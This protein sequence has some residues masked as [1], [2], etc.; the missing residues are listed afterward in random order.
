MA[1]IV[2][3]DDGIEFDG[4]T[5]LERPLGGAESSVV[6]LAQALAA[7]GHDVIACTN[8]REEVVHLGVRWT[9][10]HTD[11]DYGGLPAAADLYIA[12][13][14]DRLIDL[15]PAARRT[16][17]WIHNPAGYILKWRYLAKLWRV[18]PVIVFIGS[19]H[20]AGCPKWVPDGGRMTIPY[21]IS[22]TFLGRQPL[23]AP[24]PPRAVFTSNPLRGLDWILDLWSRHIHPYVPAAELRVYSGAATYGGVGAAKAGA[25]EAVLAKARALAGQGVLVCQ[26]LAKEALAEALRAARVMLYRGDENETFCL[27]VGEAQALGLPAVVGPAGSMAERV[28]DGVTGFVALD[29]RQFSGRAR[30][31]LTDDGLWRRCHEAALKSRGRWTWIDAAGAF[32]KLIP[33]GGV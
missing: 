16:V 17:F 19:Y 26:P 15:M 12:N 3:A 14:G 8:C 29:D 2:I 33:N 1:R 10:V 22:A 24:P 21:G 27:A 11:S 28:A 6:N 4:R 5:P 25:M 7:R 32:E 20:A 23:A 9:P 18:R 30:Q 31:I 13:R